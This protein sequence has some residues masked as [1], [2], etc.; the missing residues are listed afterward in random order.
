MVRWIDRSFEGSFDPRLV[1]VK[2]PVGCGGTVECSEK[3]F[4]QNI[5]RYRQQT[6]PP[7]RPSSL[8]VLQRYQLGIRQ[9]PKCNVLIQ[10][11][12]GCAYMDCIRCGSA[13]YWHNALSV[14]GYSLIEATAVAVQWI[15]A[16]VLFLLLSGAYYVSRSMIHI[17]VGN[18]AF[19]CVDVMIA[20]IAAVPAVVS[21]VVAF[22]CQT[23]P[24]LAVLCIGGLVV[25]KKRYQW[26][27]R[28]RRWWRHLG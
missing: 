6:Q 23:V 8:G 22:F 4:R 10:K 26:R 17:A 12:G 11:N 1:V 20:M 7:R 15:C 3:W 5:F 25:G 19:Y 9:C 28:L 18:F 14:G 24:R 27:R 21:A 16:S 13:F 2:C